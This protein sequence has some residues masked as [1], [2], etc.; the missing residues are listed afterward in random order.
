MQKGGFLWTTEPFIVVNAN[1]SE[2]EKESL[3]LLFQCELGSVWV[4]FW[5]PRFLRHACLT[6]MC[7]SFYLGLDNWTCRCLLKTLSWNQPHRALTWLV[8][9]LM[10]KPW[11]GSRQATL[12]QHTG[13]PPLLA[14]SAQSALAFSAP[15]LPLPRTTHH[16][17]WLL[18]LL[19]SV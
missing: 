7:L 10:E 1:T 19:S 3:T 14:L 6:I 18:Q 13:L 9:M 11:S 5:R 17:Y 15:G 16:T 2:A 4:F 12:A 8:I